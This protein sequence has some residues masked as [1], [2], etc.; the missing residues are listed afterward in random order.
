[1]V[2]AVHLK[3]RSEFIFVFFVVAAEVDAGLDVPDEDGR[4]SINTL[5]LFLESIVWV[6]GIDDP[7]AVEVDWCSGGTGNL[8]LGARSADGGGILI[9][10]KSQSFSEEVFVGL[11]AHFL[12][13]PNEFVRAEHVFVLDP[14][15]LEY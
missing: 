7:H 11:D 5:S 9:A 14:G 8:L 1:M 15:Q 6:E 4:I 2:M 3:L 12:S 10:A 13:I